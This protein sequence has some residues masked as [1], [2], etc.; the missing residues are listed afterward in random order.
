MSHTVDSVILIDVNKIWE[1][2]NAE[3]R[4]YYAFVRIKRGDDLGAH[5]RIS[6]RRVAAAY[7][8]WILAEERLRQAGGTRQVVRIIAQSRAKSGRRKYAS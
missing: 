5:Q 6:A 1:L 2:Y 4:A 8:L 7:K 3:K